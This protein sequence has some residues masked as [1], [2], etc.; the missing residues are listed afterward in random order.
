VGR[1]RPANHSVYVTN[2]KDDSV[3]VV[4]ANVYN[5]SDPTGC[6][7]LTPP[8]IHTGADPE[9][10]V[11]DPQTQTLYTANQ[12]D[13]DISVIDAARCDAQTT[14]GCRARAPEVPNVSGGLAADPAVQ[15]TYV[16]SS[17][18]AVAMIDDRTCNAFHTARCAQTPPAVSVRTNPAAVAVDPATHTVYVANAGAGTSGTVSVLDD[19][20]CNT[21]DQSGC[22]TVSTL[23]VPD[24][25]PDGP[26]TRAPT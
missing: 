13:N 1:R 25:N 9:S 14:S 26:S 20:D 17:A 3:I 7:T 18:T 11:L 22:A 24:G 15:T 4:N 8:E 5:G 21:T 10:V 23:N 6:A 2:Q 12:V 19:R 16:A